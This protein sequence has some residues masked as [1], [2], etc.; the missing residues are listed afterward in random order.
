MV[1]TFTERKRFRKNLGRIREV[2]KLP[3]L[4]ELQRSSYDS[5]LHS[6]GMKNLRSDIGLKEAFRSAF[7][8]TDTAGRAQVDFCSYHFDDPKYSEDECHNKGLT[9]AASLRAVFRL[10]VWE[11]NADSGEKTVKDVKEQDVYICDLP[12][13]TKDGTFIINGA[14]RVVVSQMQ[15]SPGVFFDHDNG[16]THTSGKYLFA[17]HIIPYKGAW[18]D[19]EFDAKDIIYIRI[20]RKRKIL[21]S[22]LLMA[23]NSAK[24]EET[25]SKNPD[26]VL[27]SSEIH[28]MSREE[29]L[30]YFY[31]HYEIHHNGKG[32]L[33]RKYEVNQWSGIKPENDLIDAKTGKVVVSAREKITSRLAKKLKE[34]GLEEVVVQIDDLIGKYNAFDVIDLSNGLVIAEA[35]DELSE[36]LIAKIIK[37]D[38]KFAVL[39]IDHTEVGAYI[40]NTLVSDKCTNREEALFEIF[41]IMRPGEPPTVDSAQDMFYNMFFNP[42]RYDLSTVG[43]VK[44]NSRIG[45]NES[46]NLGTLTKSDILRIVK[47]L[48]Q[49]KDGVGTIDDIDNLANRRVRSVGELMENQFRIGLARME[50]AT[51]ERMGSVDIENAVPN[52]VINAKPVSSAIREFFGLS[53]LSQFMDQTN[54]LAEITHKRRISALGPGGLTRDRAGFDV[55]DVHT[56]HYGRIC[57]IETPEGQNIGL[58][59]SLAIFAKINRYGFIETPYRKV[60]DGKV[61]DEIVYLSAVDESKYTIAQANAPLTASGH[62]KDEFVTCRKNGDFVNST[63]ELID[64][65]DVSPKQIISTAA[66]LIPFLENDDASRA[67]MGANM[68]RQAVPL[69]R[70]EAP[71]VGTGMEAVVANDSGVVVSAKRDGI[72]DQVDADRIVIRATGDDSNVGVDIYNLKKFQ[73]SNMSTCLNQ[74]P[75]VKKGDVVCANDIIADGSG[76]H[77]GELALGQ[78]VL[79]GFMSWH[80][81]TFEDAIVISERL[82]QD[83]RFTSIHIEEFETMARD[84]KLGNEEITRD[85]PNV[86]DDALRNLDEAGIVHVE[87]EVQAGDILVGKVTPKG[88]TMMTP[89]EKL[90]RA[91]FG[92][93]AAD[94]KDSSLRLPPGVRGTV[95]DV[96]IFSRCGIEKDERSMAIEQKEIESFKND[97]D[98]EK[99]IFEET[100]YSR[101]R[102][103]L[104]GQKV[105]SAPVKCR[106]PVTDKYLNSMTRGQWRQITVADKVVSKDIANLHSDFNEILARLNKKFEEKVEKLQKGDELAPGVLKMVKVYVADKRKLQPGDKLAGRHGNKGI[107][108]KIVPVEDMPHM[109]DGTPLDIILNPLGVTSRMNVGQILETHLGWASK[110]LGKK[111][112]EIIEKVQS[113][114]ELMSNLR[115]Q[116]K[117]IY[118]KGKDAKDID[119]MSDYEVAELTSNVIDGIPVATPVFDGAPEQDIV[120][121]L[122]SCGLDRSGQVTLIDGRTGV[123]FDRKITIGCI[124]M[125]K[126]HHMVDD[127]IHARSIGP[128]SLVTQQPLGGK[129]QFGGQRFG[130]ME[131]WALQAYGAAYTLQEILTVKSDDV[132]GRIKAYESIIKG[133]ENITPGIPESFNVLMKELCGLGLNF[134][135]QQE[136]AQENTETSISPV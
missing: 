64:F 101:L 135:F 74:K 45:S 85:I 43:R 73:R 34:E 134:E 92:E 20:D 93:R 70:A 42:D 136:T 24:T 76:T 128:Y 55:R 48:H 15:R 111:V 89:E 127:K 68:Q 17:A 32:L 60:M 50:K 106:G 57:P 44:M 33:S 126:L 61:T 133:D 88:E 6:D 80:G 83:D 90:L 94:V 30:S 117:E 124:Y 130:E 109:E 4:I 84:T 108:S 25:K 19:V 31:D 10:I 78:N 51:K 1:R 56:T 14:E 125:L 105:T 96:K 87:A 79:V 59:N 53:Q 3:N 38:N 11:T 132:T 54:P 37:Y 18:L 47:I 72:V 77:I 110:A 49:L 129:A 39:N 131:V 7:P 29:I 46:E 81:Y 2:A 8:I 27:K 41:R 69:I 36:D 40:R 102:D 26:K 98:A 114:E 12:V 119:N 9:Y 16:K 66:S 121:A 67:L 63:K 13:M 21:A 103:K 35:G 104:M 118:N 52:D 95:V 115:I 113:D 5:F 82:V 122:E 65:M 99:A 100:Y 91:I 58:I 28:G 62:F 71:L 97:M 120:K 116:L 123:P 23:L 86:S 22:T 75:L 107:V 112:R